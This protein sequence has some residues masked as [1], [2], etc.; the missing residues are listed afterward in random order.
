MR[1]LTIGF[2]KKSAEYFFRVISES[3]VRQIVDV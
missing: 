3:Q 2:T 1:I